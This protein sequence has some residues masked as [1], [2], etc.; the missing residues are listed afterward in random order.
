MIIPLKDC[1]DVTL[2]I[3]NSDYYDDHDDLENIDE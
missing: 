1:T 2:V 3:E